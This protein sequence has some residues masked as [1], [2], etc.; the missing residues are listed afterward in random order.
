M[1]V[2]AFIMLGSGV[3][4]FADG[5]GGF[6]DRLASIDPVLAQPTNPES[7]LFRDWFEVVVCNRAS[8]S[9]S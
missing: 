3:T 6:V 1:L 5:L 8:G 7:L 9:P 4:Y 2:V